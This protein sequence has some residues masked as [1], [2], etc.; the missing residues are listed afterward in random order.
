MR[1]VVVMVVV[2]A[3]MGVVV[4]AM[5]LMGTHERRRHQG[6]PVQGAVPGGAL[7][8]GAHT[9]AAALA[10]SPAILGPCVMVRVVIRDASATTHAGPATLASMQLLLQVLAPL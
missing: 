6:W 3:I 9:A 10:T 2:V 8:T 7:H 1:V 4:A 5:L